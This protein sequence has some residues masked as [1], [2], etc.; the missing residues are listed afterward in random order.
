MTTADLIAE[1][2]SARPTAAPG[3]REHVRAIARE[4]PAR[5]PSPFQRLARL[6]PRRVALVAL[7]AAAVV[8]LGLAGAG[9]LLDSGSPPTVTAS[10]ESFS[11][12]TT[13]APGATRALPPR[14]KAGAAGDAATPAPTTGRAQ[15]YSAELTLSVKDV[16]ALSAATQQALRITRDL[17]GYVVSVSYA[18]SENGVSTMTLKV[19]TA[20]VQEA[21]VR[22][23]GLGTIVSQQVQIDDLQGQVDELTKQETL[24]LERIARLS[25][26]IADPATDPEVKATLVARR[27]AARSQLANVRATGPRSTQRRATRRSS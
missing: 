20:N 18:T 6:S 8:I 5:R 12:A 17:G 15:R 10:R 21:V 11:Q 24:L 16:D 27:D 13:T 4:A 19:P 1:L 7:P 14:L 2:Q 9:A 25:A 23:T 26:R 22:L 3:L